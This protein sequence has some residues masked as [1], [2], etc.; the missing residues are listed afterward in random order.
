MP[1]DRP[2]P[3]VS[4]TDNYPS[5]LWF[6]EFDSFRVY[7]YLRL[8]SILFSSVYLISLSIMH[9][10]LIR[11]AANSRDN[12]YDWMTLLCVCVYRPRIFC[13][14][15][16]DRHS[17]CLRN[18]TVVNNVAVNKGVKISLQ[19]PDLIYSDIYPGLCCR[20][21]GKFYVWFF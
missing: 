13:H 15:Q 3:I 16:I 5:T 14:S 4:A 19:G 20:I 17:G 1:I 7:I 18:L 21:I 10:R 12:F 8:Y 11:V 2:L 6:F 9:S